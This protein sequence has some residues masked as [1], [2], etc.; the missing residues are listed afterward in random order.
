M[1]SSRTARHLAPLRTITARRSTTSQHPLTAQL[2]LQLQMQKSPARLFS[3]SVSSQQVKTPPAPPSPEEKSI[4]G[5]FYKTF[6]RPIAKVLLVAVFTY[7]VAY[8]LWVKLE[9][10]EIKSEMRA[11]IADLEARIEQLEQARQK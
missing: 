5:Q 11:T 1:F 2:Q 7:Q 9:Y 10:N 4:N 8:Y 3:S 6:G